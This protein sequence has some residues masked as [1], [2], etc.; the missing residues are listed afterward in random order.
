MA[1]GAPRRPR[2][3]GRAAAAWRLLALLVL[4]MLPETCDSQGAQQDELVVKLGEITAARTWLQR[5]GPD[6]DPHPL[7]DGPAVV[8]TVGALFTYEL[9]LPALCVGCICALHLTLLD[10]LLVRFALC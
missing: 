5:V 1:D 9:A 2:W 4:V 8:R 3:F 7:P 10:C 6:L